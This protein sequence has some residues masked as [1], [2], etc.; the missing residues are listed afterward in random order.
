[1]S[2]AYVRL[3][4]SLPGVTERVLEMNG[5]LEQ[6]QSAQSLVQVRRAPAPPPAAARGP[7]MR[8]RG[9]ARRACPAR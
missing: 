5:A 8:A 7:G 4:E 6:V 3:G 1:V 9:G 2:G